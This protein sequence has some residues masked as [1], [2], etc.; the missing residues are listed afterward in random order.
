[1]A[2]PAIT[3]GVA[4]S[5]STVLLLTL[6]I[7]GQG[8]RDGLLYRHALCGTIEVEAATDEGVPRVCLDPGADASR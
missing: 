7:A 6:T 3:D 5:M 4:V 8:Y 1:V 2:G